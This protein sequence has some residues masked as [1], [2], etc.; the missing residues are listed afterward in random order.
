MAKVYLSVRMGSRSMENGRMEKE[1]DGLY[2]G[3]ILSFLK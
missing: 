2:L 3:M 1:I